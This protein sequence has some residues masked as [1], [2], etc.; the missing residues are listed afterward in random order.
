MTV[1]ARP[2]AFRLGA[3]AGERGR[4]EAQERVSRLDGGGAGPGLHSVAARAR[5]GFATEDTRELLG[6]LRGRREPLVGGGV[7][8]VEF[9]REGI[10]GVEG[11][12]C[13][14]VIPS[15]R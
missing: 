4:V 7:A 5:G 6:H 12:G 1:V 10:D 9:E 8:D 11:W 15:W 13:H 3:A 2:P 14:E